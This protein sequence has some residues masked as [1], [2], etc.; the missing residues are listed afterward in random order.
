MGAYFDASKMIRSNLNVS[1][2]EDFSRKMSELR[3]MNPVPTHEEM[4]RD[5]NNK[6]RSYL[7]LIHPATSGWNSGEKIS[8]KS[9]DN[10]DLKAKA[11]TPFP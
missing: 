7:A 5:E 11:T 4:D 6:S 10:G 1:F 2:R 3:I 9:T 8:R